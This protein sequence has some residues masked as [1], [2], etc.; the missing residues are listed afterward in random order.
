MKFINTSKEHFAY[1]Q[2]MDINSRRVLINTQ[3]LYL[4][5][6]VNVSVVGKVI[7]VLWIMLLLL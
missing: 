3:L 7:P 2:Y 6:E 5:N 1:K 4:P